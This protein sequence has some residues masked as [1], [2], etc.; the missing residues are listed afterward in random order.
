MGRRHEHE[1]DRP[2]KNTFC[3][4]FNRQKDL[5]IDKGSARAL[6]LELF[7]YL[8]LPPADLSLYFVTEKEICKLHAEFFDDPRPTDC[9]SFPIDEEHLGEIFVCPKTAISYGKKHKI[10]PYT[11][12]TLYIVHGLLHLI[13][14]DDLEPVKK[15]SM[16]KKEKSCMAHLSKLNHLLK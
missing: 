14:Y 8:K 10:D 11:E 9:I 1:S 6:V 15:R 3:L 4:I 16:R 13:G 7:K 5:K 12:T 2:S